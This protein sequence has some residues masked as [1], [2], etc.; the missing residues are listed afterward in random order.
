VTSGKL[1]G[2]GGGVSA[3][4]VSVSGSNG[5]SDVMQKTESWRK[6]GAASGYRSGWQQLKTEGENAF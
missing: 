2:K 1:A 4:I 5:K 6:A 3:E